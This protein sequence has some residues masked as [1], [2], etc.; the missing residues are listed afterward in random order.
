MIRVAINSA[1]RATTAVTAR[2]LADRGVPPE[3]IRIY[4]PD[5]AEAERYAAASGAG[6]EIVVAPHDPTDRSLPAAGKLSAL[7]QARLA[8]LRHE[9]AAGAT[10]VWS[11][12]DDIDGYVRYH[13]RQNGK[14]GTVPLDDVWSFMNGAVAEAEQHGVTLV[15]IAPS[16]NPLGM[17]H[18]RTLGLAFCVGQTF[19]MRM[20]PAGLHASERVVLAEKEDYERCLLH[21]TLAGG[22]YRFNSVGALSKVYAGAGGLQLSRSFERSHA[23][24]NL[25]VAK[26]PSLIRI[27]AKRTLPPDQGRAELLMARPATNRLVAKPAASVF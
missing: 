20:N 21:H 7:A 13:P 10:W 24:A 9:Q 12:D 27:N 5:E 4:V 22:C 26:Y 15:G 6:F 17:R 1:G 23:E 8:V 19:A 2:T 11:C 3:A 25:L 16:S 14:A 18:E